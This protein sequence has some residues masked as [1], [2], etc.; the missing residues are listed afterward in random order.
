MPDATDEQG[1]G[2]RPPSEPDA[3]SKLALADF[4]AAKLREANADADRKVAAADLEKIKVQAARDDLLARRRFARTIYFT[5]LAWLALV[6]GV[7]LL[8]GFGAGGFALSDAVLVALVT[9]TTVNVIAWFAAVVRYLFWRGGGP[10]DA[11]LP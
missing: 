6:L 9:T 7:V 5:S 2:V 4:G 10:P 8:A 1:L 11:P 3:D